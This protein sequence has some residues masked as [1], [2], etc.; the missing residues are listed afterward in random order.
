MFEYFNQNQRPALVSFS[1]VMF[2]HGALYLIHETETGSCARSNRRDTFN[3]LTTWL[4]DARQHSNSNMVIMLIGNKRYDAFL[5]QDTSHI[6][7][8]NGLRPSVFQ[9]GP[10]LNHRQRQL[11][12]IQ[13]DSKEEAKAATKLRYWLRN[14]ALCKVKLCKTNAGHS[15]A[16]ALEQILL[17]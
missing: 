2:V 17:W 16:G 14:V 15:V 13:A 7:S 8:S 3:H 1:T 5:W 4:E 10:R 9:D 6:L 11:V 12:F